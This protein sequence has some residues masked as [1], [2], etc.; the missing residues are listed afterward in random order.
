MKICFVISTLSKGGAERVLSVLANHLSKEFDITIFK[1]DSMSPFYDILPDVKVVSANLSVENLGF[2]K[3][4]TKRFEKFIVLRKFLK[5][6]KFDAV[7][8]FLDYMNILTL[9]A[10]KDQRIFIS[11]HTNHSF[12]KSKI[13][14][15]LKRLTYPKAKA[16]SVLTSYDLI[17]YKKFVKNVEIIQNPMFEF[18]KGDLKKENIILAAGRLEIFKGFDV[19]LKSLSLIDKNLLKNWKIIIAGDGIL[20]DELENLAKELNLKVEFLGFVKDIQTYYEKSKIV[21]VTSRAEGF[22]NILMES[23][24]FDCARISTDCIAGPS[25]LIKDDFDGYLCEVDDEKMIANRLENLMKDED[26]RDKFVQ[27]ANF[28]RESFLVENIGKKWINL[29]KI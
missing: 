14:K 9:L 17:Y 26:L 21:V 7:I 16:L 29:I 22:C 5:E 27:N 4:L 10:N 2:L 8:S 24:F 11:E 23:I 20:R 15:I 1:F 6:N 18:Q 25:E 19:F 28:R 12:L 3:N 13:W